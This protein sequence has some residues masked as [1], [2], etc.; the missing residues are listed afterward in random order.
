MHKILFFIATSAMLIACNGNTV[1]A[2]Q[3]QPSAYYYQAR[4]GSCHEPVEPKRYYAYQWER[5]L[6]L[7]VREL[8][9]DHRAMQPI[10]SAEEKD[11][12]L[13]H[14]IPRSAKEEEDVEDTD[15]LMQQQLRELQ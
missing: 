8:E 10:L 7:M 2:P 3:L 12:L 9:R 13:L 14:I 15:K 1:I 4:C 5:L 6:T 11:H